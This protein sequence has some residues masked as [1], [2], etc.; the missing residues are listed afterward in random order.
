MR[1]TVLGHTLLPGL[2]V[3]LTSLAA[4]RRLA[5]HSSRA[6]IGGYH[7]VPVS[8][9]IVLA[10]GYGVALIMGARRW[11]D[12]IAR[13][14]LFGPLLCIALFFAKAP[15]GEVRFLYPAFFV[16][17]VAVGSTALGWN[18]PDWM[19]WLICLP[20]C[21]ALGA[22][23]LY[24]SYEF[25]DK[26]Q[27]ALGTGLLVAAIAYGI[28]WL[29]D[30]FPALHHRLIPGIA[31]V[32]ALRLTSWIYV[33]WN[34]YVSVCYLDETP[35]WHNI[36]PDDAPAWQFVKEN[37]PPTATI[38][39]TQAYLIFPLIGDDLTRH[40]MY[41]PVR[42]D[43]PDY[44]HHPAFPRPLHG[45][46]MGDQTVALLNAPAD[47]AVWRSRLA[48]SDAQYLYIK[49]NGPDE[50]PPELLWAQADPQHFG[51]I[52]RDKNT[53]IYRIQS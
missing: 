31:V 15:F 52:F 25:T 45:E 24:T 22:T 19:Q 40:V 27:A 18:F 12:P 38:A 20:F 28:G 48:R 35:I 39:Y 49:L 3:T 16:M 2:F 1:M 41:A 46:E 29:N 7:G 6:L 36:W 30:K 50:Q 32:V 44:L 34:V 4:Y 21:I 47:Q 33:Y 10:T 9:L 8:L 17:C 42:A 43:V 14:C 5:R 51:Q 37:I 53:V 23:A 13:A 11:R 26:V